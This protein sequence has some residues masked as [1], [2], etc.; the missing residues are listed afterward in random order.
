MLRTRVVELLALASCVFMAVSCAPHTLLDSRQ[1]DQVPPG[2]YTVT[3]WE[4]LAGRRQFRAVLFETAHAPLK[5]D[6]PGVSRV[7][8]AKPDDYGNLLKAG[9]VVHEVRSADG[10]VA[11][12]L[13]APARAQVLA[14]DQGARGGIVVTVTGLSSVPES[15]GGGGG[16]GGAM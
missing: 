4:D 3:V 10:V 6:L 5:I 11:G 12:Y 9:F 1:V 2:R 8:I 16:G 15:G 14:W 7:G 13:M